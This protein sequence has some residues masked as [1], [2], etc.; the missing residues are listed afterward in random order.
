[1]AENAQFILLDYLTKRYAS[2]K[3]RLTRVLG[4]GDL[5]SDALHDT[6]VKLN[7][8]DDYGPIQNPGAYLLRMTV[9]TAMNLHRQQQRVLSGDDI[10][11]L[12]A[13]MTDPSPGPEQ[14]AEARSEVEAF[15]ARLERMPERR[16][17][18]VFLVHW[19]EL[20]HAEVARVLSISERTVANELQRVHESVSVHLPGIMK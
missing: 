5:A 19:E 14:L 9:N 8:K 2:L 16:R 11:T 10:D 1:M 4:N 6:W 12:L 15:L 17:Q 3:L 13:E 20:T 18:V 7:G